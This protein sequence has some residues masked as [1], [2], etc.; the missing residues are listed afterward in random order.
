MLGHLKGSSA[1]KV[2]THGEMLVACA[3]TCKSPPPRNAALY[4]EPQRDQADARFAADSPKLARLGQRMLP[5]AAAMQSR[6]YVLRHKAGARTKFLLANGPRGHHFPALQVARA[7]VVQ[8]HQ[9]EHVLARAA[10]AHGLAQRVAWAY[11]ATLHW[12]QSQ[13]VTAS[14]PLHCLPANSRFSKQQPMV[15]HA[16]CVRMLA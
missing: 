7:P 14:V 8:Q 12:C 3:S 4:P 5:G 15:E 9:P 6:D 13:K 1:S 10:D 16:H 11:Q 2:T